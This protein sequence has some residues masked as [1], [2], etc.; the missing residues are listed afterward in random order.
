MGV[1][2]PSP[3]THE[4]H[5]SA[6]AWTHASPATAS[7]YPAAVAS[8]AHTATAIAT[9][10]AGAPQAADAV[11]V[12]VELQRTRGPVGEDVQWMGAAHEAAWLPRMGAHQ[13][14]S[15]QVQGHV[16]AMP[17]LAMPGDELKPGIEQF[18]QVIHRD[19]GKRRETVLPQQ[20]KEWAVEDARLFPWLPDLQSLLH[21]RFRLHSLRGLQ[22]PVINAL[23]SGRDVFAVMPTG[24][25]KSLCFQLPA[26]YKH[27]TAVVVSP[28]LSLMHDQVVALKHKGIA[29]AR[30][31]S[32]T[33]ADEPKV[34]EDLRNGQL[35]M[36][37]VS[38]ELVVNSSEH[39]SKLHKALKERHAAQ[40]L[41]FF[42]IDEAHCVSQ[43]GLDFRKDYLKLSILRREFPGVPIL[44]VSASATEQVIKDVTRSLGMTWPGRPPPLQFFDTFD[45]PNLFL[46]VRAKTSE[47]Q[48]RVEVAAL[49]KACWEGQD[50]LPLCGIVYCLSRNDC[51]RFAEELE[52][53]DNIPA[54][55]YHAGMTP[56]QRQKAF[57]AWM[58]GECK[59]I[60]A[61][62]AFGMGIDKRDVR[63]VFHVAMPSSVERYHQEVGRAGRDG[64]ACRCIVW[65]STT[66]LRRLKQMKMKKRE[67]DA[68]DKVSKLFE[69]T[70]RCRRA[71]L[72]ECF[73]ETRPNHLCDACDVCW[74]Q[75]LGLARVMEDRDH[76][77]DAMWLLELTGALTQHSLTKARLR[78]IAR[79]RKL[80]EVK[81]PAR[82][83]K[84]HAEK[85]LLFGK[86]EKS[87]AETVEQIIQSMLDK[88]ILEEEKQKAFRRSR[89][90]QC[91]LLKLGKN[92]R[93]LKEGKLRVIVRVPGK[94]CRT[95]P[96]TLP[97]QQFPAE[98]PC[99]LAAPVSAYQAP[100]SEPVA[101]SS[102]KR[103][104]PAATDASGKRRR[105]PTDQAATTVRS[106]AP[107]SF[108]ADP[109]S[110][111]NRR[112]STGSN[113][114]VPV[115]G[116]AES[117][118][119]ELVTVGGGAACMGEDDMALTMLAPVA[120]TSK[121]QAAQ[122][123]T[124]Q[125][126]PF[127]LGGAGR[128]AGAGRVGRGG[129]GTGG[130]GAHSSWR[131][132]Q[133]QL[134]F[135]TPAAGT[136]MGHAATAAGAPAVQTAPP[137][138]APSR[139]AMKNKLRWATST[140]S[141]APG[142]S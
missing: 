51:K 138:K 48:T 27:G 60:C 54:R 96:A 92:W 49:I 62:V 55:P 110:S 87:D 131:Q 34:Y 46:E 23:L 137:G 15:P 59:V 75:R 40:L 112:L 115:G 72:L 13:D 56:K 28:L 12:H 4:Q 52:R 10:T 107:P 116:G 24:A 85:H 22:L 9:P 117:S 129:R 63:F 53:H 88:K 140:L 44:C 106:P 70:S 57:A 123:K 25:G 135:A 35:N 102:H 17:T 21:E 61:T 1:E 30:L 18:V 45:R 81:G 71:A 130:S 38:P 100:P 73:G 142:G 111:D 78:D 99:E 113:E 68:I 98:A 39:Q 101:K 67:L 19:L 76:T 74:R 84:E 80:G 136:P 120:T 50:R 122:R 103:K 97:R 77:E 29:A 79:G 58:S 31:G 37:Y 124:P 20:L 7:A 42:V 141:T 2:H 8:S 125:R 86:L 94:Q 91:M 64:G 127:N 11:A 6:P 65:H 14:P 118:G 82:A 47:V 95:P 41:P 5:L 90:K 133:Q 89:F 69:D 105:A 93:G 36:L 83:L 3:G 139:A 16:A 121:G 126:A 109:C 66:D 128:G 33:K 114:L 132:Q 43:W 26:L 134:S 119:D 104:A 108:A 32:D